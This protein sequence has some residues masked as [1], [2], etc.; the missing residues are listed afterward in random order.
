MSPDAPLETYRTRL[1]AGVL[2]FQRDD[3]DRAVFPPRSVTPHGNS[4]SLRW[5]ES[6]GYG[7]IYAISTLSKS[8]GSCRHLALVNLDEGFRMLSEV[9]SAG[10]TPRIGQP[11]QVRIED[12]GSAGP[13]PY[14]V[15]VGS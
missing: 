3:H 4:G 8:D 12:S 11:V 15:I 9:R 6:E 2:A 10:R 5:D 1:A 14:F 7:V 13:A